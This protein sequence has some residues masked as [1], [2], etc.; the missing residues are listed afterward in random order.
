MAPRRIDVNPL[1]TDLDFS[2]ATTV[3]HAAC[4][5]TDIG[6]GLHGEFRLP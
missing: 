4:D 6:G 3:R 5:A 2:C 1:A